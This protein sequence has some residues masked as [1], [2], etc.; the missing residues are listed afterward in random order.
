MEEPKTNFGLEAGYFFRRDDFK[1]VYLEP[2]DF[3]QIASDLSCSE[4]EVLLI[5][6][7]KTFALNAKFYV[8]YADFVFQT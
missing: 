4:T 5:V 1:V 2:E 3:N 7:Q 6:E 8:F